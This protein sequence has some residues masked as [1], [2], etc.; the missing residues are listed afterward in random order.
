MKTIVWIDDKQINAYDFTAV[1]TT[2]SADGK[3]KI[4]FSF[5]VS[6]AEY[7]DVAVLLYKNDFLVRVPELHLDFPAFIHNYST[8]LTDLYQPD[9]VADYYLELVE[10]SA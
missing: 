2:G 10:K 5:K 3:K 6:S 4:S 8:D 7:H 9:Q 1:D